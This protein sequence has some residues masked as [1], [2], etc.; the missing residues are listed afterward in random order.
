MHVTPDTHLRY[1]NE[2]CL[3][4]VTLKICPESRFTATLPWRS[5]RESC[6]G[7]GF[8]LDSGKHAHS[9]ADAVCLSRRSVKSRYCSQS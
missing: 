3:P 7:F 5:G 1:T 8:E 6:A 4:M 2:T 9:N